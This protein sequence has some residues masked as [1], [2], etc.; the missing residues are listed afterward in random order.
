[1][2][3]PEMYTRIVYLKIVNV[4]MTA[5]VVTLKWF[6]KYKG[7]H[8]DFIKSTESNQNFMFFHRFNSIIVSPWLL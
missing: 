2:K 8:F 1:M 5:R 3:I 4:E 7:F 6:E